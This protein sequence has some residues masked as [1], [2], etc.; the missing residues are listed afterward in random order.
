MPV[1]TTPRLIC[2]P[3]EEQDWPFYLSLQQDPEVMK[4]VANQRPIA[5]IRAAFEPRLQHWTPGSDHWLCLIVRDAV[6][7]IPL[8]ATGYIHREND[9]AEVGFLFA[10]DAQGKGYG[11]ESLRALCDFAFEQGGIRRLTAT[12]TAGNIASRRLLEKAGFVLEGELRENFWLS[13]G[14]H[15]DWVFGLLKHEHVAPAR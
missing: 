12:V 11:Y 6:S 14:W 4:F 10:P 9:C 13:G 2:S 8:G 15:N 1:I 7:Q 3:V 5:T